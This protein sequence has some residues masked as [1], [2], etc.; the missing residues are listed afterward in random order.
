MITDGQQIRRCD[1]APVYL[2]MYAANSSASRGRVK[3]V[4]ARARTSD[5]QAIYGWYAI[6][7]QYTGGDWHYFVD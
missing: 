2:P 3:F 7:W 4:Y 6:G 5:N 1:V